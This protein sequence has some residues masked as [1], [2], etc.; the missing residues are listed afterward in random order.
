MSMRRLAGFTL[1]ELVV[2]LVVLAIAGAG[3]A[4]AVQRATQASADPLIKQ[5][6]TAIAQAYLEEIA[7]RPFCDP[8]FVS[9][10]AAPTDAGHCIARCTSA[11]CTGASVCGGAS[12]SSETR[13]NFDDLCDYAGLSQPPTDQF[14]NALASLAGY[15]VA[16]TVDDADTFGSL[17]GAAGQ[18]LRVDVDVRHTLSSL[19]STL[20]TF[21]ANY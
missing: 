5:Q 9:Q 19:Q 15:T 18:V 2:L 1:I 3:M 14:G 6:A 20:S 10:N 8:D 13:P 17:S 11:A 7:L 21:R 4:L 16:V 12:F